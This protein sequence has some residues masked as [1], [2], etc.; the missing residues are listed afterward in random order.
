MF[1]V[2]IGL[3]AFPTMLIGLFAKRLPHPWTMVCG[4]A[5]GL[6]VLL[7][8]E[9]SWNEANEQDAIQGGVVGICTN[10]LVAI[11]AEGCL[12]A[13]RAAAPSRDPNSAAQDGAQSGRDP[14]AV[15][16]W[17]RPL[18]ARFGPPLSTQLMGELFAPV[19]EPATTGWFVPCILLLMCL[20]LPMVAS[21]TFSEPV[22]LGWPNWVWKYMLSILGL[23]AT[24]V[25]GVWVWEDSSE[26]IEPTHKAVAPHRLLQ[27]GGARELAGDS[28]ELVVHGG[29]SSG[30]I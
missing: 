3:Q 21:G 28:T 11:A 10:C 7:S 16:A 6:A 19:R 30:V 27:G 29:Q 25:A 15:P 20:S 13:R 22:G 26:P 5:A 4:I 8:I 9:F 2:C 17:D 1:G 23:T 14:A 24:L 12:C 18:T